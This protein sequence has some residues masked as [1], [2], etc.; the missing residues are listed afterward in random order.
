[1]SNTARYI[2]LVLA[3][4]M[5]VFSAYIYLTTADWVALVFIAGSLGYL[6]FFVSLSREK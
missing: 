4:A 2:G 6:V 3:L 5:L 1:M